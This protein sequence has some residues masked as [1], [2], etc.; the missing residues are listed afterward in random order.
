M[1][2]T[3]NPGADRAENQ[4]RY[5]M[6]TGKLIHDRVSRAF[7]GHTAGVKKRKNLCALS[8]PQLHAVKITR[9]HGQIT[10]TELADT[11]GVSPP[12]ASAMV[13]RLAEKGVLRRQRSRRDRRKVVVSIPPDVS[14]D[15]EKIEA[16]ILNSF[17]ELV[18]KIGPDAARK[19]CEVLD[20]VKKVLEDPS[21]SSTS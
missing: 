18:E 14:R 9:K 19:W 8:A 10:I 13:D 3:P 5:I 4:A 1:P 12:S 2:D 15:I 21:P 7:L 6:E 16:R 17:L 20:H 11:L